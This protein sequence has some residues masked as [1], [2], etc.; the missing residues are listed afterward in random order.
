MDGYGSKQLLLRGQ[1]VLSLKL[2]SNPGRC[3]R[4]CDS[5]VSTQSRDRNQ[6]RWDLRNDR[7]SRCTDP[8]KPALSKMESGRTRPTLLPMVRSWT[9]RFQPQLSGTFCKGQ[10]NG[11]HWIGTRSGSST[12]PKRYATNEPALRICLPARSGRT[13]PAQMQQWSFMQMLP[14]TP[15]G[16][17]ESS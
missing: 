1:T 2:P 11:T 6:G 4:R 17:A 9:I 15:R 10:R 7:R 13:G 12:M 3:L 8:N 16:R 5:R 14:L